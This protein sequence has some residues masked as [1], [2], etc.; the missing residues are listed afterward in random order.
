[1]FRSTDDP[2][3]AIETRISISVKLYLKLRYMA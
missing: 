1:M 3:E 2:I